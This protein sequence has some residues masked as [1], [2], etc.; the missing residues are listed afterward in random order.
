MLRQDVL[1][2]A[3]SFFRDPPTWKFLEE[4][5]R[6]QLMWMSPHLRE[7]DGYEDAVLTF[8]NIYKLKQT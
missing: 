3:I 1:I 8:V 6:M 5:V 2:G 4:E 7:G